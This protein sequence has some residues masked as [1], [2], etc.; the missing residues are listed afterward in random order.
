M[1]DNHSDETW[2]KFARSK[3]HMITFVENLIVEI[4]G[5]GLKVRS[6]RCNNMGEHQT[7]LQQFCKEKGIVLD[8]TVPNTPQQNARAKKNMHVFWQRGMTGMVHVNLNLKSQGLFWAES[9]S[10][11]NFHEDLVIKSRRDKPRS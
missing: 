10:H 8:Y 11:A 4:N 9:I 7:T 6:I 5:S 3:N 2:T 1:V